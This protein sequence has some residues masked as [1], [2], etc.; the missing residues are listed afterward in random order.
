MSFKGQIEAQC[1][2]DCDS[3]EADVWSFIRGD[4][5]PEL[6]ESILY[7]ECNLLLCPHCGV[8]FMPEAAWI[9]YEPRLEL[10]AFVFPES[11]REKEQYWRKKMHADFLQMKGAL[12]KDMPVNLE[13]ELFFGNED[14]AK[15]L[16]SEDFLG[17]E[18]E[19]MEFL[20]KELGLSLY[21]VSPQYARRHGVPASLPYAG[22]APSRGS[23]LAGLEKLIASNDRLESYARYLAALRADAGAALPP[24]FSLSEAR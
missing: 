11:D 4:A 14:I 6:R 8:A 13:P 15:L 24:A 2:G 20:A 18:R 5:S 12:G 17:E 23:V 7:R 22:G 9:Y 19:V 1:P 21:R 3:F 10:L 16:E